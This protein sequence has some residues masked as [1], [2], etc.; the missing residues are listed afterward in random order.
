MRL[1]LILAGVLL[2]GC[3]EPQSGI[4]ATPGALQASAADDGIHL[5]W[6]D[7][8]AEVTDF[9]VERAAGDASAPDLPDA[10]PN[11]VPAFAPL[12]VVPPEARDFVD[13]AVPAGVKV[14]Y[15]V[16]ALDGPLPS[17]PSNAVCVTA[18]EARLGDGASQ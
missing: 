14:T 5:A 15:R 16:I 4:P 1:H 3:P 11:D 18:V 8:G 13:D 10:G 2:A 9:V 7:D 6:T 12:H 17:A